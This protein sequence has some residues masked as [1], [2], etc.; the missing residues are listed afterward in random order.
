M[1]SPLFI[2]IFQAIL[3]TVLHAEELQEPRPLTKPLLETVKEHP[4]KNILIIFT[5]YWDWTGPILKKWMKEKP[6]VKLMQ[7]E[8]IMSYVADCTQGESVGAVEMRRH[9]VHGVPPSAA[10]LHSDGQIT[11]TRLTLR[12][13]ESLASDLKALIDK[14]QQDGG[15]QAAARPELK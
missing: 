2:I 13:P 12:A 10:L 1:R 3:G 4:G 14:A 5:A 7:S 11:F 6:I 8:G 9:G 15:G